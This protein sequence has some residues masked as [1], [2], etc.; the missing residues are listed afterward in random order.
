MKAKHGRQ[1]MKPEDVIATLINGNIADAKAGARRKSH[2]D[3]RE[4]AQEHGL[5]LGRATATADFLKGS[6]SWDEYC[7]KTTNT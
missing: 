1:V 3:L 6:L 5:S 2:K 7:Q 4:A